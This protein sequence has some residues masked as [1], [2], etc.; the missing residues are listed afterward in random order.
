MIE[1]Y[2]IRIFWLLSLVFWPLQLSAEAGELSRDSAVM[3]LSIIKEERG[4]KISQNIVSIRGHRGQNQPVEWE[5]SSLVGDGQRVFV[6]NNK[7]IIADTI[8]SSGRGIVV[9]LRRLKV[10]SPD[11]FTLAHAAAVKANVGFD[12]ID[13]ELSAAPLGNSPQWVVFLRDFQGHDVGRLIISGE[14]SKILTCEWFAPRKVA[15]QPIGPD[16]SSVKI[17]MRSYSPGEGSITSRSGKEGGAK[18]LARFSGRKL[19]D[20][21]LNLGNR[22][23]NAFANEEAVSLKKFRHQVP[24]TARRKGR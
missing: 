6:V 8:Y 16:D 18:G 23:N 17:A 24:K 19:K 10:D 7:K 9:D 13:Y 2:F 5:I 15:R 21:F 20:G 1:F 11:V 3:A 22:I 4:K 12:S 14:V